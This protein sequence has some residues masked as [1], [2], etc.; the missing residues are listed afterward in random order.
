MNNTES[1]VINIVKQYVKKG[2]E[3]TLQST[4]KEDLR[5]DSLLLTEI[6]VAC[7]DHFSIEIDL[8]TIDI[9]NF[10]TLSDLCQEISKQINVVE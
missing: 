9:K 2:K 5:L 8:D 10:K 3:V 7:E 1:Q 4:L 6:I